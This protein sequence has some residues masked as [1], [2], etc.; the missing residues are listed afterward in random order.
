M[1]ELLLELVA[2][3]GLDVANE[4]NVLT[5]GAR[6]VLSVIDVTLVRGTSVVGW[7]VLGELNSGS[8]HEYIQ[9]TTHD[10]NV[11]PIPNGNGLYQAAGP[12]WARRRHDKLELRRNIRG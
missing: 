10:G 4:G 6:A 9:F 2:S 3:L 11:S 5:F 7:R 8:D 1:D 12:R